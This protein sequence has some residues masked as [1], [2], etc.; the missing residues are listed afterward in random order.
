MSTITTWTLALL[1]L[2]LYA[3]IAWVVV[4]N[5]RRTGHPGFLILGAAMLVWLSVPFL[6]LLTGA[7]IERVLRGDAAPFPFSLISSGQATVG[8]LYVWGRSVA[9]AVPASLILL[10]LWSL[11]R[12]PHGTAAPLPGSEQCD[13]LAP[14]RRNA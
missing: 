3:G 1:P 2:C 9:R 5:Y 12:A 4:R 14:L 8:D 6:D 11:G 13:R 7:M 10:G